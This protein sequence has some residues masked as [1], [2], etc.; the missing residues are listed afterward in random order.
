MNHVRRRAAALAAAAALALSGCAQIPQSSEVRAGPPLEDGSRAV[1]APQFEPPGP[2]DGMSAEELI[3]GFA[4]AGTAPQDGYRIAREYLGG[5][6]A[7]T[8][9]PERATLVYTGEPRIT[10]GQG[11]GVYEVQ[12]EVESQVDEYGMRTMAPPNTTLAREVRVR[13]VGGRLRIV[14]AEDGILLSRSQFQQLYVPHTLHFFDQTER[15]AV[16]DV[17]WFA[18]RRATLTDLTRA[19]LRG[20]AP[21][22]T[23]AVVTA[24]PLRTGA[25]LTGPSVPVSQDGVATV[26][27]TAATVEGADSARLFRMREQLELT[28]KGVTGVDRVDVTVEGRALTPAQDDSAPSPAVVEADWG[29]VQ[30]AVDVET[31]EIVLFQG[32][33]VS[34]VGGLPSVARLD[35]VD[36]TSDLNRTRFAFLDGARTTLYSVGTDGSQH[37]LLQGSALTAPTA[38]VDGWAWTVDRGADAHISAVPLDGSGPRRLVTAPWLAPGESIVAMKLGFT[39]ARAA[40]IVDDGERRTLRVAGVVRGSDGVPTAL[41]EPV[42]IPSQ[43]TP[44]DMEWMGDTSLVVT[45][46]APDDET[47]VQPEVVSLDGTSRTLNPLAGLRGISAGNSGTIYA[48]TGEDVFLLVGSSWRA[49]DLD[50][51]IRDLAFPG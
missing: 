19:L 24:F 25:D 37:P 18:N 27:L 14:S 48:E 33:D 43:Q 4:T 28:L 51:P 3:R 2:S 44:D 46:L 34:P 40:L 39:G 12:L 35:P 13:E 41:T 5:E 50:E 26:D 8:W 36:P 9:R 23:G 49:Q 1:D 31:R 29:T 6:A 32:L 17:R 22:L 15:Y 7:S 10:P 21:Y 38:D 45:P 11:E 47:R 20:P 16:P 42:L 30:T